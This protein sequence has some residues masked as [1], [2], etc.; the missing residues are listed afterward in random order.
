MLL[1]R[2]AAAGEQNLQIMVVHTAHVAKV[3]SVE[4]SLKK[5]SRVVLMPNAKSRPRW[6]FGVVSGDG[7]SGWFP[8][9]K[10]EPIDVYVRA[11]HD[12]D[13]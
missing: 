12:N 5:G 1:N 8:S 6:N 9:D 13:Q 4:L 3:S 10:V 11:F 7:R 2:F